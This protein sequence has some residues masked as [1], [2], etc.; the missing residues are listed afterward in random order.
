LKK[1]RVKGKERRTKLRK[2]NGIVALGDPEVSEAASS[3]VRRREGEERVLRK[4]RKVSYI[5]DD[6][7]EKEDE[8]SS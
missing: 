5:G 7:K 8:R 4:K 2:A 6:G 3:R 1:E